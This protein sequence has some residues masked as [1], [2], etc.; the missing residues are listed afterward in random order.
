MGKTLTRAEFARDCG[1]SAMAIS[2]AAKKAPRGALRRDR[3]V[4]GHSYWVAYRARHIDGSD[5]APTPSAETPPAAPADPTVATAAPKKRGRK[6]A[7]GPT[8]ETPPAPLP[9]GPGALDEL[10][11]KVA[12][13]EAHVEN[14]GGWQ[15]IHDA[16][17]VKKNHQLARRVQ[18]ENDVREGRY[19]EREFVDS[20]L[21]AML[22]T[23]RK[24]LLGDTP[25]AAAGD[26]TAYLL[27][28]A[29]T[30]EVERIIR[31]AISAQLDAALEKA[32]RAMS[33]A[34]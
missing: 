16:L 15:N 8:P 25:R 21:W 3:I 11:Q 31:D 24:L 30:E 29:P 23:E 26:L 10:V 12:D 32:Q 17:L 14:L 27:P 20:R 5:G 28:A 18:L 33:D 6:T 22:D 19:I 34:R 1:V 4:S 9:M 2:K 7:P 13:L